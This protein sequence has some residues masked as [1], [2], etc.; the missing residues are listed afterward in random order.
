MS[1]QEEVQARPPLEDSG[2]N[3]EPEPT[4]SEIAI[5]GM[6][7]RY[8]G[9]STVDAFWH[10][11]REGL[12]CLSEL[13][14]DELAEAGVPP[15]LIADPNFVRRASVLH[16]IEDFDARFFGYTPLEVTIMD[17]QHR[18]FLE[19]AWEVLEHGGYDPGRYELPVG[20]FTGAKTNT[21]LFNVVAQRDRFPGL[22][23]FQIA[24]GNDL[25]A[26]ATRVSY[27]LDLRGPSYALHT[28]CSTSLVAVHLACQS[29][30]L[31]ECSMAIAGGAAINYPQKTGYAYQKGG[32]LSP[33]GSC[34]TFDA[35][36]AGSNFGNGVGAVLLK[37]LDDALADGDHI[38]AVIRGSAT[39]N[40]GAAKASFT[41]PGVEGQTAV[42][43][44]AMAVAGIE[45]DDIDYIEAHGTATDLGDSIEMLALTQAFRASS[46]RQ[47]F[48]A[49]GSAKTNLGHLETAAG[50]AG[51][52]KTALALEHSEL[53][54]SLHY[55]RPNPKIDFDSSPFEVNAE[56]RPWPQPPAGRRR[57][58]GVSSFGI[59][60]TNAHVLV[61]EAP[62][63]QPTTATR[64]IQVLPLAARSAKA[65]EAMSLNLADHLERH[66]ELELAD[67]A[68]TLQ[69]GRRRFS[70]RRAVLAS[71]PAEA[72][73]RLRADGSQPGHG[74]TVEDAN[75]QSGVSFL[76]PG[77]GDQRLHL[78]R[79]LYDNDPVF[80]QALDEAFAALRP[81]VGEDLLPVL[82]PER[83][84]DSSAASGAP[85]L[86]RMLGR[87]ESAKTPAAERL[88][89]TRLS[90]PVLFAVELSLARLWMAW[91]VTPRAMLGY[92]LG[93]YATAHLAG[94]L[95]L[96]DA[97][98]LVA[99]RAQLIDDLPAGAML[100]VS[101]PEDE[102]VPRLGDRLS[103]AAINGP[104]LTVAAGPPEAVEALAAELSEEG[105]ACRPIATTHAF[106]SR[107]MEPIADELSSLVAEFDLQEPKIPYVSNVTGT[108]IT[109]DEATDPGYWARH[110]CAPVRF[111]DGVATLLDALPQALLE[112]GSGTSLATFVRLNEACEKALAARVATSLAAP[113][114]TGGD[115]DDKAA[116]RMAFARLWAA[117]VDVD[118]PKLHGE[119]VRRRVPLPAYPFERERLWLDAP[120]AA[121]GATASGSAHDSAQSGAAG[122]SPTQVTLE[123]EAL[124]D[125]IYRPTW[126]PVDMP[127]RDDEA[128]TGPV[129]VFSDGGS[130]AEAL[131]ARLSDGGRVVTQVWPAVDDAPAGEDL[132]SG[133]WRSDA[134]S[135]VLDPH[136]PEA[137]GVLL[138]AL[139]A[140]DRRPATA[141][142]L[143]SLSA[144]DELTRA[145]ALG[146]DSLLFFAQAHGRRA[147]S[148]PLAITAVTAGTQRVLDDDPV[149][150][151]RALIVGP[152]KVIPQEMPGV[153]CR[154]IDLPHAVDAARDTVPVEAMLDELAVT[155]T[156]ATA[157][158]LVTY[159]NGERRQQDF[160]RLH[161]QA[162][163]TPTTRL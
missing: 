94:V 20:V 127:A 129:L 18:L 98:R 2:N 138:E 43:L 122:E 136:Q 161:P 64:G 7:C 155:A 88:D 34:R 4:G 85:D 59:G 15:E 32:I 33:D 56:L 96:E 131:T 10:N 158:E 38:H 120:E 134:S 42:L 5:I 124:E 117:G 108:W 95:E 163:D 17:P 160:E 69:V 71:T 35:D 102:L 103:L 47:G 93:E 49:L 11:L 53:P 146:F 61:E 142:H 39:N 112:M 125:W 111:A 109:A 79:E 23:N 50:V 29:L 46:Q 99:R 41:A 30:L 77:L 87:G 83:T 151:E 91:G 105:V 57:I 37:R 143:W 26:M 86:R 75:E 8:P 92:S 72:V 104:Q 110:L 6:S 114:W 12:E 82:Y 80:R 150:P 113:G 149:A 154:L 31:D 119:D 74:F 19:C 58:A 84:A 139:A 132:G 123:R 78:A 73:E 22:D 24:L 63:R 100:G 45:A 118:W 159:R 70:H 130:L 81:H 36:A 54:P 89:A 21:Y 25:A 162:G 13:T 55:E 48:C 76:L 67:V 65:L 28:A 141:A 40:D 1:R 153:S 16:G 144:P 106:H 115:G 44:E 116:L 52:M 135:Y 51:L 140:D 121:T 126:S 156:D 107:M 128:I 14:D 27:K 62:R 101:L 157:H 145:R 152:A 97:A 90:Q 147:T 60:S 68:H 9:A 3:A 137:Y 148:E 133:V 66:P